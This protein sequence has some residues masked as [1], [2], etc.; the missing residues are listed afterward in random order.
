MVRKESNILEC[1]EGCDDDIL[2]C[3]IPRVAR[4]IVDGEPTCSTVHDPVPA[5][6][7]CRRR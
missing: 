3:E 6:V 2:P 1:P 5:R 7:S 4:D